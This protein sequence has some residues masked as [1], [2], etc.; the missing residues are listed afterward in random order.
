[1][2]A[3]AFESGLAENVT[4]YEID[5]QNKAVRLALRKEAMTSPAPCR[6]HNDRRTWRDTIVL[7][8]LAGKV[9]GGD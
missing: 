1:M 3:A 8:N 9:K 5:L 4:G 6:R 2:E 7:H